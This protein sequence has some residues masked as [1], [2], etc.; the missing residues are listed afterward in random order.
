MLSEDAPM[1]CTLPAPE[2]RERRKEIQSYLDAAASIAR[3]PD[4]VELSFAASP[5]LAHAL[6]DFIL[7]E[8]ACC[9]SLTYELR[10]GPDHSRLTLRLT[11]PAADVESLHAM[12]LPAH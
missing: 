11:A 5:Q 12:Y 4:G 8:R 10:S 1:I 9:R 6:I 2:L 7:F 3:L